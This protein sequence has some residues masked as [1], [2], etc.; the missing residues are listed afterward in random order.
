MAV[1]YAIYD[2]SGASIHH[3]DGVGDGEVGMHGVGGR[4]PWRAC[5]RVTAA[6]LRPSVMVRLTYFS[7]NHE[8]Y[9]SEA[10]EWEDAEGGAGGKPD[11]A[12]LGAPPLRPGACACYWPCR[13][14]L[15]WCARSIP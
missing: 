13:A 12:G 14:L 5:F 10:F 15:R 7:I 6:L 2:P 8:E 3:E 1:D 4:G 9:M 11:A